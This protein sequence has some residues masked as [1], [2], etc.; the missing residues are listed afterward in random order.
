MRLAGIRPAL[1]PALP[2]KRRIMQPQG[3]AGLFNELAYSLNKD[4][5]SAAMFHESWISPRPP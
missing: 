2:A 4:R 1:F 5:Y 3:L